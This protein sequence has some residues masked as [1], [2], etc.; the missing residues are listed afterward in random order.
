MTTTPRRHDY[1]ALPLDHIHVLVLEPSLDHDSTIR[2]SFHPDNI[3]ELYGRYEAVSY[4]W[5]DLKLDFPLHHEDETCVFVTENLDVALRR[6]RHRLDVR[7]LWADAVCMDQTNTKEKA[8]QIPLMDKIYRGAKRVFAWLGPGDG[9][10]E[11]GMQLLARL[12]Q[13][14]KSNVCPKR[15]SFS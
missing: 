15:R 8:F 1:S 12:S 7:W 2:F 13:L 6:L 5:G 11:A 4:T 10:D 9:D 3:Q 14:P